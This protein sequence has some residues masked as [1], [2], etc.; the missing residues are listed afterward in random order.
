MT[1]R[2][3]DLKAL[4]KAKGSCRGIQCGEC[5]L[6]AQVPRCKYKSR[7]VILKVAKEELRKIQIDRVIEFM[8]RGNT[9]DKIL[10]D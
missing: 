1:Q 2:E 5:P 3:K 6:M 8:L 10:T 4:I 9:I 7:E